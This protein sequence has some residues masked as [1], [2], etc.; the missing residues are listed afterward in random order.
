[1]SNR[2]Q[3]AP[4]FDLRRRRRGGG[5]DLGATYGAEGVW[6]SSPQLEPSRTG[7]EMRQLEARADVREET[8]GR[9]HHE[10]LRKGGGSVEKPLQALR[11]A[12]EV[13]AAVQGSQPVFAGHTAVKQPGEL[14]EGERLLVPEPRSP[15]VRALE[16][17]R[18]RPALGLVRPPRV[19][20]HSEVVEQR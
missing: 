17:Q 5:R 2:V 20:M 3:G 15:T 4:L 6:T 12:P 7:V 8:L 18:L 9:D 16:H 11:S 1:M 19:A 13:H 10:I 14:R